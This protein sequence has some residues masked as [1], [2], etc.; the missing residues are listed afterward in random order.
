MDVAH[1][2][3]FRGFFSLICILLENDN[4]II[5]LYDLETFHFIGVPIIDTF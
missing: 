5:I 2:A 3:P 1:F 4:K